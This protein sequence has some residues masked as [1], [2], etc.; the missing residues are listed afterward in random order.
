MQYASSVAIRDSDN[1]RGRL[2]VP[3]FDHGK[4]YTREK[5]GIKAT[6]LGIQ[7]VDGGLPKNI[8]Q[9][10]GVQHPLPPDQQRLAIRRA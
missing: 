9:T 8:R 4:I 7:L 1:E 6:G 3:G 5:F 10:L 2:Q